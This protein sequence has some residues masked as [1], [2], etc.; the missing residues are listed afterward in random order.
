MATPYTVRHISMLEREPRVTL[1]A[2]AHGQRLM[3]HRRAIS[4]SCST[5]ES[6]SFS[7]GKSSTQA[8]L[9]PCPLFTFSL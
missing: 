3:R 2:A 9:S 7:T 1:L 8:I 4:R 5:V 6:E